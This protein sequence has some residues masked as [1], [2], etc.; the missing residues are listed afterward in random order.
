MTLPVNGNKATPVCQ[1]RIATSAEPLPLAPSPLTS[2]G[3]SAPGSRGRHPTHGLTVRGRVER[4]LFILL[5][6]GVPCV[7]TSVAAASVAGETTVGVSKGAVRGRAQTSSW[8]CIPG[9]GRKGIRRAGDTRGRHGEPRRT[10]AR[11]ERRQ[12][13]GGGVDP[14]RQSGGYRRHRPGTGLEWCGLCSLDT[15]LHHHDKPSDRNRGH[16]LR[17][18][19]PRHRWDSA[20]HLDCVDTARWVA[21]LEHREDQRDTDLTG[22]QDSPPHGDEPREQRRGLQQHPDLAD[23]GD[24][25]P[26]LRGTRDRRARQPGGSR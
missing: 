23:R 12:G 26:E 24:I 18:H 25:R 22:H 2:G 5:A 15:A 19:T 16:H 4:S 11:F 17:R 14:C 20:I 9:A 1:E 7:A 13:R 3:P 21:H 8:G 6:I 10:C